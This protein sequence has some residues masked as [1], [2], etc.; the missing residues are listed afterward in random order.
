[1]KMTVSV[2]N[3]SGVP[4]VQ[5]GTDKQKAKAAKFVQ[6]TDKDLTNLA[7][8]I[9][10]RKHRDSKFVKNVAKAILAVPVVA[11]G[12][13]AA[14]TKGKVSARTIAGAKSFL[15]TAGGM[16]I[17]GGIFNMHKEINA[18]NPKLK[19]MNEKHPILSLVGVATGAGMGI[20]AGELLLQSVSPKAKEKL[21]KIGK[22]IKLDR[23]AAKMDKA[24]EAIRTMASNVASKI[25]LP[26]G[27]KEKLST[28]SSK[29]KMP[30]ILKDGYSKIASLETTKTATNAM[31]KAGKAMAKNPATTAFAFIGAAIVANAVKKAVETSATKAKL[32]EAQMKTANSLIYAYAA[33]NDSLKSANAKAAAKL[34]EANNVIA[35]ENAETENANKTED[36]E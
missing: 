14:A 5:Y 30:Q 31:K 11:A 24:P 36:A 1:M 10:D 12:V 18:K 29:I 25:S 16:A 3:Q 34:E 27:V 19:E 23:L 33:E 35:S 2:N 22:S 4:Y 32:K 9:N 8:R 28:I 15:K 20:A 7:Y 17:V 13:T 6:S 21:T 26:N